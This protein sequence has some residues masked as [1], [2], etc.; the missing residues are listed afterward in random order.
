M[1]YYTV[2]K[3]DTDHVNPT[4]IMLNKRAD[5]KGRRLCASMNMTLKESDDQWVLGS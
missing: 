3:R 4:N 1:E 5:A 2:V